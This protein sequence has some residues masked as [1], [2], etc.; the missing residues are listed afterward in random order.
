MKIKEVQAGVKISK[1]YDS[2]QAS[3]SAEI[4][5]GEN[6]E[7]VGQELMEKARNIV[8]E[9]MELNKGSKKRKDKNQEI[10]IGAAWFDKKS[11]DKLSIKMSKTNEWKNIKI[12]DLEKTDSGY[13]QNTSEGV[14]VFRKIPEE[15]RTNPKMPMFRIYKWGETKRDEK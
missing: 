10:E 7:K 3:L 15:K 9:E 1:N 5:V 11:K 8:F 12:V 6:P 13:K 14:F 2:Y 4:E